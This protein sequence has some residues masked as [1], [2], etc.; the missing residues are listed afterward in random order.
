M[1]RQQEVMAADFF[2]FSHGRIMSLAPVL[3]EAGKA[4]H[5]KEYLYDLMV[6]QQAGKPQALDFNTATDKDDFARHFGAIH[7]EYYKVEK[8]RLKGWRAWLG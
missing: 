3:T 5:A 7:Y 6:R 2:I 8:E 1:N 4:I